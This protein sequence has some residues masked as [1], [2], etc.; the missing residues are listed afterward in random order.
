MDLDF[1]FNALQLTEHSKGKAMAIFQAPA[2]AFPTL[3]LVHIYLLSLSP[4]LKSPSQLPELTLPSNPRRPLPHLGDS[5]LPFLP[6][7]VHSY[8][9]LRG[10]FKLTN[11]CY[12][13]LDFG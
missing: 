13:D 3:V 4:H 8:L 7:S 9:E 2:F 11:L 5:Q 1:A 10:A 12:P 6:P